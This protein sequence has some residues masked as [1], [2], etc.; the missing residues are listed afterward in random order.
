MEREQ[1]MNYEMNEFSR[2][3]EMPLGEGQKQAFRAGWSNAFRYAAGQ[4]QWV[5]IE[6]ADDLPKGAGR[7]VTLDHSGN[8]QVEAFHGSRVN[9]WLNHI[10]AYQ[11]EEVQPYQRPSAVEGDKNDE[12]E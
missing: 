12:I 10:V 6:S 11:R 5:A 2:R 1:A 9:R 7:Y 3:I 8:Y 4:Q